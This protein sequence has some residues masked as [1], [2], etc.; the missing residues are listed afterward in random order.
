MQA[1]DAIIAI[2]GNSVDGP[3][4]L[5]AQVHEFSVGDM[6]TLTIVRDGRRLDVNT[7]LVAK[8]ANSP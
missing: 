6:V 5:V 2:N 7:T 4:S 8:P 1:N 3:L